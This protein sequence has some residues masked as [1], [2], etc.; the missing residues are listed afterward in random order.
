MLA[1]AANEK[2]D[3]SSGDIKSAF[4]Q[5]KNLNR[6]VFVVPPTEANEEGVLWLLKKGAYGLIDASRMFF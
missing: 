2:F 5:G 4:L 1:V 6:E 3:L